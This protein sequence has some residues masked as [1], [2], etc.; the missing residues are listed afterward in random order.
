[1]AWI[2]IIWKGKGKY[3]ED[4]KKGERA[5]AWKVKKNEEE[6]EGEKV[7]ILDRFNRDWTDSITLARVAERLDR[8]FP[9]YSG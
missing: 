2:K 3:K 1:M 8:K 5:D 6:R 9:R 7:G 4:K